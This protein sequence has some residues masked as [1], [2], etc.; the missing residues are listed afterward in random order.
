M[1]W[2]L[3][4]LAAEPIRSD[5]F[6]DLGLELRAAQEATITKKHTPAQRS[7]GNENARTTTTRAN[8]RAPATRRMN[9]RYETSTSRVPSTSN[10]PTDR[11]TKQSAAERASEKVSPPWRK[12][13]LQCTRARVDFNNAVCCGLE[14]P[15]TCL[16]EQL[17]AWDRYVYCYKKLGKNKR[18]VSRRWLIT[19]LHRSIAPRSERGL[20]VCSLLFPF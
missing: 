3:P 2:S 1:C 4:L 8:S 15:H 17:G 18:L 20:S 5:P 6:A 11:H 9:G 13:C 14:K 12:S 16:R 19:D 7:D 10:R